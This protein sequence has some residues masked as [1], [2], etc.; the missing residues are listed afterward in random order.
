ME[1]LVIEEDFN[2]K[3]F[4]TVNVLHY[5]EPE[6]KK[7]K[8]KCET[9]VEFSDWL[10]KEMMYH[11]WSKCEYEIVIKHSNGNIILV[12]W[13]SN[14]PECVINDR[15]GLKIFGFD[16]NK[17]FNY[18]IKKKHYRDID[19]VKIDIYDQLEFRWGEFVDYCWYYHHK[20]QRYNSKFIK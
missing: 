8:K 15:P 7:A 17:F 6:I 11:Y 16:W 10:K 1:W 2:R 5:F 9:K 18:I 4:K 20:Y 12:P 19:G 13:V 14:T 3:E